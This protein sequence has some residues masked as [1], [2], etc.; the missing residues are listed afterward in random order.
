MN[1]KKRIK[2]ETN[3]KTI[4]RESLRNTY[5]VTMKGKTNSGGIIIKE[6]S[7]QLELMTPSNGLGMTRF[8]IIFEFEDSRSIS[9]YGNYLSKI[10]VPRIYSG[11]KVVIHCFTE[12]F[13][14]EEHSKLLSKARANDVKNIIRNGLTKAGKC[15]VLL[16]EQ[17]F[18]EFSGYSLFEDDIS[19][20]DFYN[21]TVI[22][23][24]I[25]PKL[26][27]AAN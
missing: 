3:K 2:M 9:V 1:Q 18:D 19:E 5:K 27:K 25:P 20:Q 11:G 6:T 24:I 26:L 7:I 4:I 17:G 21:S 23:D 13:D 15:D 8:S 22:V 14:E 16:E 12:E 10:V